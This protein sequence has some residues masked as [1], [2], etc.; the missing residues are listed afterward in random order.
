MICERS[1]ALRISKLDSAHDGIAEDNKIALDLLGI[2]ASMSPCNHVWSI[3][4]WNDIFGDCHLPLP[5]GAVKS[6]TDSY[7]S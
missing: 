2:A 3:G 1:W 4:V 5:E 7:V 6:H